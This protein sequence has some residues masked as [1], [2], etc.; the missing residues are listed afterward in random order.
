M[1][2]KKRQEEEREKWRREKEE[3]EMSEATFRPKITGKVSGGKRQEE[4]EKK[5]SYLEMHF[6]HMV[7]K[8]EGSYGKGKGE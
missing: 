8:M 6:R 3:K 7:K 2:G 1:A 5:R 4:I